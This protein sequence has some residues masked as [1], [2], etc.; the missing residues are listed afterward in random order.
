MESGFLIEGDFRLPS[1]T[2]GVAVLDRVV[3]NAQKVAVFP[4]TMDRQ[5]ATATKSR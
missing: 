5:S 4:F 3:D 2:Q 1:K